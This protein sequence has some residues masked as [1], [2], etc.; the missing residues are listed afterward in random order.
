MSNA[1]PRTNRQDMPPG[2]GYVT[3]FNHA[4]ETT[5]MGA[6]AAECVRRVE[7][8][9][10]DIDMRRKGQLRMPSIKHV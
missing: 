2:R 6:V 8:D 9:Q 3:P 7:L 5:Y 10:K 4:P 1:R